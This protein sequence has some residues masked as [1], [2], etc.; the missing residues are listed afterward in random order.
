MSQLYL[1]SFEADLMSPIVVAFQFARCAHNKLRQTAVS[2]NLADSNV[3][4]LLFR[5]NETGRCSLHLVDAKFVQL[6]FIFVGGL[7]H[8]I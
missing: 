6:M 4:Q 7:F 1:E 5:D 3:A 8:P 2:P